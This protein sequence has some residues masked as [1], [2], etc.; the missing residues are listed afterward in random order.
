MS[1]TLHHIL[2]PLLC[3]HCGVLDMPTVGPGT[4]PHVAS[5]RCGAC[6][7]FLKWAPR[8][9]VAPP[10]KESQ[11]MA[12]VNRVILVGT[13]SKYGIERRTSTSGAPCAS[14]A[15]AVAE[16]GQDGRAHVTLVPCE[17]WGKKVDA[18]STL[19]AGQLALFEGKLARRKKGE[20]WEL[21]VSGYELTPIAQP[22]ASTVGTP[23]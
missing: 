10:E 16:L 15:L 13:I 14:F 19:E 11:S 12:G 22:M 4:G 1:D 17:V 6:G 21:V 3:P 9:L 8:S 2:P 5:L 7:G 20:Q 23:N 18:A